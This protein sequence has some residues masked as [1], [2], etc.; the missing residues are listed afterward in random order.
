MKLKYI[1]IFLIGFFI[2]TICSNVSASTLNTRELDYYFTFVSDVGRNFSDKMAYYEIDGKTAYC[3]EPG[4]KLCSNYNNISDLSSL[5]DNTRKRIEEYSYYGYGFSDHTDIMYYYATQA[6]IW[7]EVLIDK[8]GTVISTSSFKKG[9]IINIDSYKNTIL[10]TIKLYNKGPSII[11]E[12]NY[13]LGDVVVL[14]DS[15][16]M[17]NNYDISYDNSALDI[18]YTNKK[19]V[20]NEFKKSGIHE[21]IFNEKSIYSNDYYVYQDDSFQDLLVV[22]NI[23]NHSFSIVFDIKG[24]SLTIN[25]KDSIDDSDVPGA[26]YQIYDDVNKRVFTEVLTDDNGSASVDNIPRGNYYIEEVNAPEGYLLDDNKY[27]FAINEDNMEF[28]VV[29]YNDRLINNTKRNITNDDIY[30]ELVIYN[31]PN[32][33]K[34]VIMP[35]IIIII[36]VI[37]EKKICY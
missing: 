20:I 17:I 9:D 31:V 35:Y 3:I 5:N 25:K 29:L 37:L 32:T 21:V 2:L 22:G 30:D 24:G 10:N 26:T 7:D 4:T 27:Y 1:Y 12:Y 33:N 19:L 6:L 23:P 13:Y 15:R 28:N 11:G 34:Y 8:T 14:N 18:S 16:S 36:G